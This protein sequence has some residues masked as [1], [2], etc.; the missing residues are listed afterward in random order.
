MTDFSGLDELFEHI[1]P[2]VQSA[3]FPVKEA[4]MRLAAQEFF[5]RTRSWRHVE[6]IA[7]EGADV[8]ITSFAEYAQVFEL[9]S[10][11]FEK[12]PL[13][14]VPFSEV[15]QEEL[16]PTSGYSPTGITQIG[17]STF[18][19]FPAGTGAL[20][21]TLFLEPLATAQVIPY[22]LAQSF[23]RHIANGAAARILLIPDQPYTNP[24]LAAIF[25]QRFDEACDR[26]SSFNIRG[27]HRAPARVRGSYC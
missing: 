14:R 9:E 4:Q 1:D 12:R 19:V 10:A 15:S 5:Q 3:P 22:P 2:Y 23:G 25:Q 13:D 20:R 6:N 24:Q 18:R 16:E 27:Q 26:L 7:L 8:E 11:E 21:I 17:H